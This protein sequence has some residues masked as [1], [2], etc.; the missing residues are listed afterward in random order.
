MKAK[1]VFLVLGILFTSILYSQIINKEI[2]EPNYFRRTN[3]LF[4]KNSLR[5]FSGSIMVHSKFGKEKEIEKIKFKN[6]LVVN[7]EW[8]NQKSNKLVRTLKIDYIDNQII[9]KYDTISMQ[10]IFKKN[11]KFT[12]TIKLQNRLVN[13]YYYENTERTKIEKLNGYIIYE[14][15]KLYFVNGMKIRVEHFYDSELKK[16]KEQ[17]G[18]FSTTVGNIEDCDYEEYKTIFIFDG[19]YKKWDI[20]GNIIE[21]GKYLEGRKI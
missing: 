8:I 21:S 2:K 5:P 13:R 1:N 6:G 20:N 17:Y 9:E 12:D 14:K 11:D 19:E 10:S 4:Y 15:T 3:I 7:G 16:I 18:I